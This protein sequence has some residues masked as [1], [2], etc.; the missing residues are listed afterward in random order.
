MIPSRWRLCLVCLWLVA[1]RWP[2]LWAQNQEG[3]L[4]GEVVTVDEVCY[5]GVIRWGAREAFW[6][7][8]FVAHKSGVNTLEYLSGNELK[9]LYDRERADDQRIDW[10]FM[11]LWTQPYPAHQHA[12]RC[13]FGD[14]RQLR[15]TG[16]DAAELTFKDGSL[17]QVE[18]VRHLGRQVSVFDSDDVETKLDWDRIHHIS[19][20]PTP[21]QPRRERVAALY[22]TVFTPQGAFAGYII[23]DNENGLSTDRL[24][25]RTADRGK[26][27][28]AYG[29]IAE[30]RAEGDGAR[31]RLFSGRSYY[32][33]GT[34][35]VSANNHGIIVKRLDLGHVRIRWDQFRFVRFEPAVGDAGPAY[36][37][38]RGP[39]PLQAQLAL[40]DGST[41][42]GRL[43][44]DLDEGL[45]VETIEGQ[46]DGIYYTIP[47]CN[48]RRIERRNHEF[49]AV[50]LHNGD[51]LF[52]GAEHDVSDR[53]WGVLIWA[54]G[55]EPRY[56]PW[57]TVD[58]LEFE[59]AR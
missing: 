19:F 52:L 49:S 9:R 30:I 7:D 28:L 2:A 57:D 32:L 1:G 42:T 29:D 27:G 39:R 3:L 16:A 25:G 36:G 53:N 14:L 22:G 18:D 6:D 13:R 50:T 11:S 58:F 48:V 51:K 46:Q 59:P 5:Q 56:F 15:V 17:I 41:L 21:P 12:F 26:I 33:W 23:W 38:F 35:D 34:D 10:R 20:L 44:L 8:L 37:D 4:Y 31:V 55:P 40:R 43:I 45:D 54:D 47:L 24:E